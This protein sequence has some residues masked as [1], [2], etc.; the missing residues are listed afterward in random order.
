VSRHDANVRIVVC[1]L[2]GNIKQCLG[3]NS[4]SRNTNPSIGQ[5]TLVK[6]RAQGG[7]ERKCGIDLEGRPISASASSLSACCRDA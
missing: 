5:A 3:C 2:S 4:G 6:H 7:S 1:V